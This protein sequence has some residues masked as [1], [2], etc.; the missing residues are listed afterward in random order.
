[1]DPYAPIAKHYDTEHDEFADDI[2]WYVHLSQVAGPRVLE[3]GCG[4][5]RLLGPLAAAGIRAVGLDASSVMLQRAQARL[6][7]AVTRGEI[8]LKHGDMLNLLEAISGEAPFDLIVL[9]LNGLLH[10][11]DQAAQRHV[12]KQSALVL[13]P[14]GYLALDV[15]H[16]IPDAMATFDGRVS[17]E[18]SWETEEGTVSKFSSRTVDWTNQRIGTE[19][20]YDELSDDGTVK[21]ARTEFPMRWASPAEL[22]LMLELSGFAN[23]STA[24]N[25]D[26]SPLTDMSDRILVVARTAEAD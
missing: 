1:M 21:R 14:G 18:G 22:S 15:L 8:L 24:G 20:W 4:S 17:H 13:R 12:L 19:V 16:A 7:G 6:H 2:D 23:W 10:L 25:Y 5:G 11:D 3:L 9:P 26:G